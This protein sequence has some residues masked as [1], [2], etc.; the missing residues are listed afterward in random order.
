MCD[1]GL[2]INSEL[3]FASR[4]TF[5]MSGFFAY[6]VRRGGGCG[7]NG[8]GAAADFVCCCLIDGGGGAM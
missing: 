7:G 2:S 4:S 3:A 5:E 8:G 6:G 1:D